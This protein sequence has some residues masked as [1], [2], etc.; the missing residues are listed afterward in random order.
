[1][2]STR[3]EAIAA[4]GMIAKSDA[5]RRQIEGFLNDK[6]VDVRVAAVGTL[7]DLGFK[8]S[9]PGLEAALENDPV[10]EVKFA[11]AKA[12]YKLNDPKGKQAL[13]DVVT[14][15]IDTT[16]GLMT[17]EKRHVLSNLHSFHDASILVLSEGGGFVPLPGAGMGL[18][19]VARLMNDTALTPRAVALMLLS[20]DHS[21]DLDPLLR[22]SLADKDWSL[23][24]TAAL[25][26]ALDAHKEMIPDLVPLLSDKEQ[27]VRFR[28]A[29]AYLRLTGSSTI[30]R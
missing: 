18:S 14:G 13:Q 29:G 2:P 1:M 21:T 19:E 10:P 12:L 20:R 8:E 15:K 7:A 28:A 5:A 3:A 6:D 16:S 30:A 22:S 23:R 9:I 24:A 4:T 11:A 17:R 26:I 27:K 25:I